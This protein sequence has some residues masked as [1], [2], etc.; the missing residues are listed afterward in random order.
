MRWFFHRD[1]QI[2]DFGETVCLD[3]ILGIQVKTSFRPENDCT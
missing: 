3:L 2:Q 1:E